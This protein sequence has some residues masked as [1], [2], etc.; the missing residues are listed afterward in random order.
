MDISKIPSNA[1]IK[2]EI[3]RRA[4][5]KIY[6]LFPDDGPLAY[7]E[8]KKHVN[9]FNAGKDN[10]ERLFI[11]ANRAGKTVG[12]GFE[13][14]CHLTGIYPH[15][16]EGRKF[17]TPVDTWA[18]GD[19]NETTRDI[20][21]LELLGEFDLLGTGMIPKDLLIE[22]TNKRGVPN[23][24]DSIQVKHVSGGI[25]RLG[26][27]SYD[28]GRR[29]FQG[30]AKHV[31]WLDE[32]CP[33]D[34]YSECL[35]RTMTTNGLMMLTFTPLMGLTPLIQS[36]VGSSFDDKGKKFYVNATWDDAPHLSKEQKNKL[37]AGIPDFQREARSKGVPALGSGKIYQVAESNIV[38]E[39]FEIPEHWPRAY[40]MDV[41]W[42]WTAVVWIAHDRDNNIFYQ[43]GE[44]KMGEEKPVIHASNIQ[45]RGDWIKGVCDYAGTNQTDGVRVIEEYIS[46]GLDLEKAN[47]G[48]GSVEAG[49]FHVHHLLSTSRYKIFSTN[50][51]TLE[52]YRLYRRDEKGKVV[53]ENDHLMDSKRYLMNFDLSVFTTEPE[54]D[55]LST[56][57]P[58]NTNNWMG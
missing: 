36:F 8:Y 20:L 44:Y 19:T 38:C 39:P 32:E 10:S 47:K 15:W 13:M 43:Y 57:Y 26:F 27:K 35:I 17:K 11:A 55:S 37:W 52:E 49:I 31:I 4:E 56:G 41:G 2:A 9:F 33:E 3:Q 5:N 22:T 50:T 51:G 6:G 28:S 45:A 29:K 23:A 53:K 24:I 7:T 46:L 14:A 16:W 25:S 42:N 58:Q 1:A 12:G 18:A 30:T 21:Q 40:G 34:V 54:D 48:A